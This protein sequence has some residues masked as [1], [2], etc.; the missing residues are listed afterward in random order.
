[1]LGTEVERE[2]MMKGAFAAGLG[3]SVSIDRSMFWTRVFGMIQRAFMTTKTDNAVGLP[4]SL[5]LS[6]DKHV[7]EAAW[8]LTCWK[9]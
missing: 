7:D 1:M 4:L 9:A 5:S 8:H 6:L 3:H 2:A